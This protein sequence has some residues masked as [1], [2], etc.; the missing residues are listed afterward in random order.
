MLDLVFPKVKKRVGLVQKY[1]TDKVF[2]VVLNAL[3][4]SEAVEART[5]TADTVELAN[6]IVDDINYAVMES[7]NNVISSNEMQKIIY[8]TLIDYNEVIAARQYMLYST[9]KMQKQTDNN[10]LLNAVS[11]VFNKDPQTL[12]ENANKNAKTLP[13]QRDLI[14]SQ[15]FKNLG[16]K[17]YPEEVQEAHKEGLIHLHDLDYSPLLPYSN[18]CNI[19]VEDM[20]KNGF[21]VNEISIEK[22]K[23]IETAS[24][25]TAEII[26]LLSDEQYGGCSIA[27]V[28][29]LFTPYAKENYDKHLKEA[30][31]Y[32]INNQQ[33]Y[34]W[35]LTKKDIYQA[36]QSL[37]YNINFNHA[38]GGQT[39]FTSI[40]F[41]LTTDKIGKE[42]QKAILNIR[43]RGLGKDR[44]TAIFPKL[45]FFIKDGINLR[46]S[47]P[48]YDIKQLAIKCS[49]LRDYP[50]IIFDKNIKEVTGSKD[51]PMTPMGCVRGQSIVSYKYKDKL[52]TTSFEKMWEH[53][54]NIFEVKLQLNGIDKYIDLTG[55]TIKDSHSRNIKYVPCLRIIKNSTKHKW[56]RVSSNA[57][58]LLECTSEHPLATQRGRVLAKDL[59]IGD[60]IIPSVYSTESVKRNNIIKKTKKGTSQESYKITKI[61]NINLNEDCYDVTT[62]SDFFDVDGL[63]SHNCRSQLPAWKNSEGKEQVS[64]RLNM[65]VV[66]LNLV[67]VALESNSIDEFWYNLQKG[68]DIVHEALKTRI[69]RL[70]QVKPQEAPII[71]QQGGIARLKD[72]EDITPILKGGRC[73]ASFGYCGLYEV[74][75]R[76]FG[77]EWEHNKEAYNFALDIAKYIHKLCQ[78]WYKEE[79]YW[80]SEYGTPL[81]ATTDTFCRKDTKQFGKIKYITDKGF[82]VN[83]FHY[84]PWKDVSPFEKLKFEAPFPKQSSGGNI[85][86]VE[87]ESEIRNNLSALETVWDYANEIGI[88]YLGTNC[89]ISKCLV[90]NY[91]GDIKQDSKGFE[92]PRCGNRDPEKLQVVIR[93]C[94]YLSSLS[95]R[96]VVE[97]RMKEMQSRVHHNMGMLGIA[98]KEDNHVITQDKN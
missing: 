62:E 65:G 57:G 86:Y 43:I 52:Y 82:Y 34:A 29:K 72:N 90:C 67:R 54:K 80:Y 78:K 81:E 10:D 9:K 66:T 53:F 46:D 96:P 87:Y 3:N 22:P 16:L 50:D 20:L 44:V 89:P 92:C 48:N 70:R 18:C 38:R 71:W 74:A 11:K 58:K 26:A 6:D 73:T 21:K 40:S 7:N 5:F 61:E 77:P 85:D 25:L 30:E 59:R 79:G 60:K 45:I 31:K 32:Q 4:D 94:G 17:M 76:F 12:H 13:T 56:Y 39:P 42:I 28:D 37:E 63:V 69:E 88:A 23:S 27:E 55:V 15:I 64:G 68:A 84:A 97:G 75:T 95:E 1:S 36:M 49:S 91:S 41:G 33:E 47:D 2:Q 8:N 93:V 24:T 98:E 35:D 19:N 51:I 83:S 14:V